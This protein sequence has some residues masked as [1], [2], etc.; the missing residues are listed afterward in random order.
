MTRRFQFLT[1]AIGAMMLVG[2]TALAGG[3]HGQEDASFCMDVETEAFHMVPGFMVEPGGCPVQDYRD[4]ELQQ[5][6]YPFTIEDHLFNCEYFGDADRRHGAI[7][8]RQRR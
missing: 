8:D 3:G 2:G 4:G 6:F 5:A 7:V 1:G